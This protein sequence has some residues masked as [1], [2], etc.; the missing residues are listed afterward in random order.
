[1]TDSGQG[2]AW[3]LLGRDVLQTKN[4]YNNYITSAILTNGPSVNAH[5]AYMDLVLTLGLLRRKEP[6]LIR[7]MNDPSLVQRVLSQLSTLG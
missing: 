5:N 3:D 1:M 7:M 4:S 2:S 6:K